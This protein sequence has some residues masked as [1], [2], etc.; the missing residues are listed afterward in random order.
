M[1]HTLKIIDVDGEPAIVFPDEMITALNL[2]EGSM[3]IA[4]P[5]AEG[6]KLVVNGAAPPV[7][8]AGA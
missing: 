3:L 4:I 8:S 2:R 7:P 5:D 6:F 1:M